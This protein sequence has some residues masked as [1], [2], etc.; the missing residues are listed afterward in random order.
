MMDCPVFLQRCVSQQ[1]TLFQEGEQPVFDSVK[2]DGDATCVDMSSEFPIRM[3]HDNMLVWSSTSIAEAEGFVTLSD[4]KHIQDVCRETSHKKIPVLD[5]FNRLHALGW[6]ASYSRS[7][8]H[9]VEDEA[10]RYDLPL[11]LIKNKGYFACVLSLG[12]LFS[13]GL[14][15][16]HT[17]QKS[18][19]YELVLRSENK[20][21]IV[22]NLADE[23]YK[24]A[25]ENCPEESGLPA[26]DMDALED[27]IDINAR[28]G[29][30]NMLA[31][32]ATP[33]ANGGESDDEV[34]RMLSSGLVARP[35]DPL[36]QM[37]QP[38][39]ILHGYVDVDALLGGSDAAVREGHPPLDPGS[40][41]AHAA[42]G[43]RELGDIPSEIAGFKLHTENVF[44]SVE[45]PYSRL[46]ITC[47]LSSCSHKG[48]IACKTSRRLTGRCIENHGPIEA[49]GFLAL[50]ASRANTFGSRERHVKWKPTAQ[51]VTEFLRKENLI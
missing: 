50:W 51:E 8:P 45:E 21:G 9:M 7:E 2:P 13:K 3:A 24:Q 48:P 38:P 26:S 44:S 16:L 22:P 37:I 4:P 18:S 39:E 31:A 40:A 14:S 47:P 34:G 6:Q 41:P 29:E 36:P 35:K 43:G 49:A 17:K 1:V 20:Q 19:Y 12:N 10:K 28:L 5:I 32:G 15:G 46:R 33:P 42:A 25:L 27:G 23:E 30:P 11:A